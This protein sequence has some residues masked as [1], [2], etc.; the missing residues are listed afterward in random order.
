MAFVKWFV[1]VPGVTYNSRGGKLPK[2]SP[3]PFDE[4]V[5]T[6]EEAEAAGYQIVGGG[7]TFEGTMEP[8]LH[9]SN[10]EPA[11]YINMYGGGDAG[12]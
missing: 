10:I 6:R 8:G 2:N 3:Q 9:A 7:K 5:G 12:E 1:K 11:D 4:F